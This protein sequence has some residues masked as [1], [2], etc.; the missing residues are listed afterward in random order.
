MG[1][2]FILVG[3]MARLV[4]AWK[5]AAGIPLLAFLLC[6][7]I[8]G[9]SVLFMSDRLRVRRKRFISRH[10]KRPIYDYQRVW[11]DFTQKTAAL[12]RTQELCSI[13]VRIVSETLEALSVTIWLVDEQSERLNFSGSTVFTEADA[14]NLALTGKSGTA[15]AQ[16]MQDRTMPVHVAGSTDEQV[17]ELRH[18]HG[19]ALEEARI[20]YCIPLSAAGHFVGLMTVSDT[21]KREYPFAGGLRPAENDCGPGSR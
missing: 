11:S 3:V 12:T 1:V 4:Y 10:F 17:E 6:V 9:L 18:L 21:V 5:G 20:K 19:N 15:L 16:I 13:L 7:A 14:N 2:Y 8:V